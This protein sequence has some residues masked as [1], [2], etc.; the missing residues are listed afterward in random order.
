[1]KMSPL[2]GLKGNSY[3]V[4]PHILCGPQ[5]NVRDGFGWDTGFHIWPS[6]LK[7]LHKL[8]FTR[9]RIYIKSLMTIRP[10]ADLTQT[11]SLKT[12]LDSELLDQ[13][14]FSFCLGNNLGQCQCFN[15]QNIRLITGSGKPFSRSE[16]SKS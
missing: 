4:N 1:M 12:R 6:R 3:L 14:R 2:V 8:S 9:V 5:G 11:G 10:F 7:S 15:T 13:F 16:R